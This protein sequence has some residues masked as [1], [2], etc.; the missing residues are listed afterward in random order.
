MVFT[1]ECPCNC[2]ECAG[3]EYRYDDNGNRYIVNNMKY[4]TFGEECSECGHEKTE[5]RDLGRK[6]YFVCWWCTKRA[7]GNSE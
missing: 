3:P 5:Y 2:Y 1:I 7:G 4:H 6:G